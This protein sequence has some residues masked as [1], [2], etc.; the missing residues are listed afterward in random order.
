MILNFKTFTIFLPGG[1][2]DIKDDTNKKCETVTEAL[3]KDK[4]ASNK[5]ILQKLKVQ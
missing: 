3:M 2:E 1:L 5:F 4:I